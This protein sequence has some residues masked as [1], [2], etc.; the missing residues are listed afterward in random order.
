MEDGDIDLAEENAPL[1]AELLAAKAQQQPA[2]QQLV[3]TVEIP[4]FW[5][6]KPVEWFF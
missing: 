2:A 6:T 1:R 3:N 5:P 4:P